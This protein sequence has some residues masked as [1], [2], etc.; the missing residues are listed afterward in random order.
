M[1]STFLEASSLELAPEKCQF[2]VFSR[3][4]QNTQQHIQVNDVRIEASSVVKF[5]GLYFHR[6]FSLKWDQ[7]VEAIVKRCQNPLKILSCLGHTWWGASPALL[8]RLYKALVR[9][10]IEYGAFLLH[11]CTKAQLT[12]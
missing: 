3:R 1:I 11:A 5:L 8:T 12:K 7:Q 9:S 6:I 10:R 2:C 4:R